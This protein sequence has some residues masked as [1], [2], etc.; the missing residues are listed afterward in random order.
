[1][2]PSS[3]HLPWNCPSKKKEEEEEKNPNTCLIKSTSDLIMCQLQPAHGIPF[4]SRSIRS[5][6][7]VISISSKNVQ[8]LQLTSDKIFH[9]RP[10]CAESIKTVSF[11]RRYLVSSC[12]YCF[13][14]WWGPSQYNIISVLPH[15]LSYSMCESKQVSH[16]IS[17]HLICHNNIPSLEKLLSEARE[18]NRQGVLF[19]K[20]I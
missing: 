11:H 12:L 19:G 9:L 7:I 15:L 2:D 20:T 18:V 3:I 1:M 8:F 13:L 5:N 17:Q 16:K 14:W 10:S 6:S 4:T